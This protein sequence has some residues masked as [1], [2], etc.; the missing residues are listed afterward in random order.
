MIINQV[1]LLTSYFIDKLLIYHLEFK[2]RYAHQSSWNVGSNQLK[3]MAIIVIHTN[4]KKNTSI[5][6]C[7][8]QQSS[9]TIDSISMVLL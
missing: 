8:V 7:S 2:P 4:T 1:T 5:S 9:P 3:L 6:E